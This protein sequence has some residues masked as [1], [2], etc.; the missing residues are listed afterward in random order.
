MSKKEELF[1]SLAST[2]AKYS[3]CLRK[4]VG[5]VITDEGGHVLSTGYNGVPSGLPH[6]NKANCLDAETCGAIHAEQNAIARLRTP[7]EAH[8]L[9]CTYEPCNSCLKLLLATSI[10]RVVFIEKHNKPLNKELLTKI[11]WV[12]N[13]S[14]I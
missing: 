6:C 4:Q 9:Y 1:L 3:T 5:C 11:E 2:L 14:N 13:A 12:H 7:K 8:T 10:K